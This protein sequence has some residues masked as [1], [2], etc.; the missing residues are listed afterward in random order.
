MRK[1]PERSP[2]RQHL[3]KIGQ[4][5]LASGVSKSSI[6]HYLN[7]GLLDEP[8][9]AGLNLHLYGPSHLERL[10]EIKV[11]RESRKLPLK[12]IKAALQMVHPRERPGPPAAAAN[13]GPLPESPL[14]GI[15]A[16]AGT[17]GKREQILRAATQLFCRKGYEA[18]RIGDIAAALHM[19]KATLYEYF[20]TKEELFLECIERLSLTVLPKQEWDEINSETDFF[21]KMK[22]RALGFLEA[23]GN[24]RGMLN[25]ARTVSYREGS[26]LAEKGRE[27]FRLMTQPMCD[28]IKRAQREGLLRDV[29][30][31]LASYF[32]LALG[33][34]LGYRLGMDDTYSAEEGVR[35]FLDFIADGLKP[36]PTT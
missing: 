19:G 4:L 27:S 16:D 29:D 31:E 14:R 34:I 2:Q 10:R 30:P 35:V 21:R 13:R 28:D 3:M 36:K 8:I 18:V 22:L 25:L 23:Y 24:Y 33:E 15:R 11:L 12:E 7:I 9:R 32:L 20:E 26:E 1:R 17:E 6:H 5:S